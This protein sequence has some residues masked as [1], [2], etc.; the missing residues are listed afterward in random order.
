[1][2]V[3]ILSQFA[4][5]GCETSSSGLIR[6]RTPVGDEE[7][8]KLNII[9][10]I[11]QSVSMRGVEEQ[12]QVLQDT[13]IEGA[14]GMKGGT[15]SVI[16]FAGD[17]KTTEAFPVPTEELDKWKLQTSE[18]IGS[19]VVRGSTNTFGAMEAV[20][21]LLAAV[22]G[23]SVVFMATDGDPTT[24]TIT[25]PDTI[26]CRIKE[27]AKDLNLDLGLFDFV[28]LGLGSDFDI[29][30][31]QAVGCGLHPDT[32]FLKTTMETI[33]GDIGK[34]LGDKVCF[35]H[36]RISIRGA[37]FIDPAQASLW[38]VKCGQVIEIPL[39]IPTPCTLEVTVMTA[40]T[41]KV[42][43]HRIMNGVTERNDND[44]NWICTR[45]KV[46]SLLKKFNIQS[47]EKL[48]TKAI[49]LLQT[50]DTPECDKLR[51][52]I[53]Q[54]KEATTQHET[55][56][57][58]QNAEGMFRQCSSNAT[59]SQGRYT[60]I[61]R[62]LS[63]PIDDM[64]PLL[65]D[66]KNDNHQVPK[67]KRVACYTEKQKE[68][69]IDTSL[70]FASVMVAPTFTSASDLLAVVNNGLVNVPM[71]VNVLVV[72]SESQWQYVKLHRSGSNLVCCDPSDHFESWC[73]SV[74]SYSQS[75]LD[76][77]Q[78]SLKMCSSLVQ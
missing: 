23:Q 24:G 78:L 53:Q 2:D 48:L 9:G 22:K 61:Y 46:Q 41:T 20:T 43:E 47:D 35:R 3:S 64:Q 31:C 10:V 50:F 45:Q 30:K 74:D 27:M 17:V 28:M 12:M 29:A 6:I 56:S 19:Y 34:F 15:L 68:T 21:R 66:R 55:Y 42:L 60:R 57:L 69:K 13:L 7:V 44:V 76:L 38:N 37:E 71:I 4:A 1:M 54:S 67:R 49:E 65:L 11:D 70:F 40:T 72:F 33:A 18:A 14:A 58:Y 8:P 62:R 36:M 52:I 5:L 77:P 51:K 63:Q 75:V 25:D 73:T 32:H 16:T 26:G 39:V 59:R